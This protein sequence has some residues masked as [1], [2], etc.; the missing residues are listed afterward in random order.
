[1]Y[2]VIETEKFSEWLDTL[3]DGATRIRL[4]RRLDKARRGNLGDVKPVGEGVF[5]M[6]EFFGPGWRL[7]Y[8]ERSGALII[9]LGGGNKSSQSSD[10]EQAQQLAKEWK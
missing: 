1:M 3:K 2:S 7:Y 10:I 9:M 4:G 6:R 5:E 8:V